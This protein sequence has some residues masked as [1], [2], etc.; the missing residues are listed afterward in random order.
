MSG[1][2]F[3]GIVIIGLMVMVVISLVRGLAAFMISLR[4]DVDR[5][6]GSGPRELQ[7]KQNRMMW[8]RIKYQGLAIL[9]VCILLAFARG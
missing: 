9:A 1:Q 2:T 7:V 6:P 5:A 4:E 8:S 3:L